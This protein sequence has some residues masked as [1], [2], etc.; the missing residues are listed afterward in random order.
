MQQPLRPLYVVAGDEPLL[1]QEALDA[2]RR[3]ARTQAFTE[4]EVLDA[5]KDFD[6]SQLL[7]AAASL[8][9]FASRRAIEVH[10][11]GGAPGDA[12]SKTLQSLARSPPPDTLIVLVCGALEWR[13]RQSAWF[14]AIEQAG[15]SLYFAAVT[16][17]QLPQWIESRLQAAGIRASA[18]A[19]RLLAE[20]TEGNLL[21]AAQDVQKLRL[22]FPDG[23]VD[24][25]GV[26]AAVADSARFEAFDL[27]EKV[28]AGDG[29]GAARSLARLREEGVEL[30]ALLGAWSFTLRQWAAA[31]A[32]FA[33][34]KNATAALEAAGVWR[35]RQAPFLKALPRARAGQVY[36]WLARCARMDFDAKSGSAESA[37]EELL[38][39]VMAASGAAVA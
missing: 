5:G 25:A 6:W 22:L 35:A 13:A 14:S 9:L 26:R 2:L 27:I 23:A 10:L 28:L 11:P 19:V 4:R 37:W 16:P 34:T 12:G 20:R 18:D 24:E 21:A 39:C 3:A 15:A 32:Q 30:P 17:E 31:A 33:Q 29:A 38:T 7:Q 36:G 1:V 8:S